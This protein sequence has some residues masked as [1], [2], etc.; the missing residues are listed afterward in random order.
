MSLSNL[1]AKTVRANIIRVS[2]IRV[3]TIIIVRERT[4]RIVRVIYNNL[5]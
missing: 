4:I 5:P 2:T 1:Q 3:R